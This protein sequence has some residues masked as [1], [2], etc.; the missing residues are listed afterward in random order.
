[1]DLLVKMLNTN[2]EKR[3]SSLECL[4]HDYFQNTGS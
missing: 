2:P 1:M 4:N 3:P